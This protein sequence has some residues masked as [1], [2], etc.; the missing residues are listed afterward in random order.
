MQVKLRA[1]FGGATWLPWWIVLSRCSLDPLL[2]LRDDHIVYRIIA[3]R[4]RSY[5]EIALVDFHRLI[6]TRS[7]RFVFRDDSRTFTANAVSDEEACEALRVL[8]GKGCRL[9]PA[10]A[11][12]LEGPRS[13]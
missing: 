1:T 12:V 3:R 7:L 9:S 2:E 10:A 8:H 6:G 5:D 4:E 11:M 13:S